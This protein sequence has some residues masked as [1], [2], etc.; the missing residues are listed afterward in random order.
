MREE[1]ARRA[2]RGLVALGL[3][4][5]PIVGGA[6]VAVVLLRLNR[7]QGSQQQPI[8]DEAST[9]AEEVGEEVAGSDVDDPW[10]KHKS[11]SSGSQDL[12][13][14]L[15]TVVLDETLPIGAHDLWRLV[16]GEPDFQS[17]VR[18][19]NKQRDSKI[20][21]WHLTKDGGAVRRV[22][23][24]TPVKKQMIGPKEAQCIESYR[25]TGH[26]DSGWQVDVTVQTP[27]VPYGD[28]FHSHLR[29]QA[30]SIDGKR[31][32]L[33]ISCEVVF[34]GT[35]M[36]KGVVKRASMEGMKESYTKYRVHLLER[37]KVDSVGGRSEQA[38]QGNGGRQAGQL[39]LLL[40]LGALITIA[41][42]AVTEKQDGDRNMAAAALAVLRRSA[43]KARLTA[44][45]GL[46]RT[47]AMVAPT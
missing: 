46:H 37:L 40:L 8:D 9:G 29:W 22:K 36:V 6:L 27:K 4:A 20:G 28:A 13:E 41:Y 10:P 11:G 15:S 21:R 45:A 25:C 43:V 44:A 39:L 23:Y 3:K 33:K 32:Q 30:R 26:P 38:N 24:I 7:S 5:S 31:T 42:L 19:L 17:S 12:A 47:A 34:T 16:M 2:L 35:C 1:D 18:E 14:P